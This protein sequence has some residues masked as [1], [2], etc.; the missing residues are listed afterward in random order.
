MR[1]PHAHLVVPR[2]KV[3]EARGSRLD[4]ARAYGRRRGRPRE[5]NAVLIKV[6]YVYHRETKSKTESTHAAQ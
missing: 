3:L 2:E 6:I 1:T 4:V 5:R